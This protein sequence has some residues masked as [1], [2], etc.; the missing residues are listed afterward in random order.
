MEGTPSWGT[1]TSIREV[2]SKKR[3]QIDAAVS[4]GSSGGPLLNDRGEVIGIIV[5]GVKEGLDLNFA[6]P[7]N[8][9]KELIE[10]VKEKE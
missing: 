10:K 7:S 5:S 4:K 3:F 1:V 8:Y 6:I 2:N 9:L